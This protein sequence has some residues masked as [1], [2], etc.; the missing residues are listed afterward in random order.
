MMIFFSA[1]LL[2]RFEALKY[3]MT[4]FKDKN[5]SRGTQGKTL[6]HESASLG[7]LQTFIIVQEQVE[8]KNPKDKLGNTPLHQAVLFG[9]IET[10]RWIYDNYPESITIIN[11]NGKTPVDI[12][13][14]NPYGNPTAP[15]LLQILSQF[16]NRF[17][18]LKSI[19][20]N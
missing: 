12:A 11:C 2:N 10:V 1:G 15:T 7:C 13:K 4:L 16:P 8:N 17:A 19:L 3:L 6:L 18:T 14:E 5:P 9:H 20:K